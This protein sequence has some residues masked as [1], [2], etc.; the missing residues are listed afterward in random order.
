[1]VERGINVTSQTLREAKRKL[2][3]PPSPPPQIKAIYLHK[4]EKKNFNMLFVELCSV[5]WQ[6]YGQSLEAGSNLSSD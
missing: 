1:M 3:V 6:Q 2:V 5:T 4:H